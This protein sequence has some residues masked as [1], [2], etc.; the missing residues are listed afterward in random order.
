MNNLLIIN[1]SKLAKNPTTAHARNA[2]VLANSLDAELVSTIEDFEHVN[3]DKIDTF[4]ISGTAFY[5]NTAEIERVIRSVDKPKIVWLNNEYQHTPNSEYG[6]LMKDFKHNSHIISN[7]EERFN[8]FKHYSKYHFLNINTLLYNEANEIIEKKYDICYY[9]TYRPNRRLYFQKYF[10]D[11]YIHVSSST[12]N[13]KK[14]NQLAGGHASWCDRF[15]W[16]L[17]T[18]TLN[19][20]KYSLYIEDEYTHEAFNNLANRFYEC[21][22]CNVVQFFDVSCK[23]TIEK[24]GIDFDDYFFVS[25]AKEL[26]RKIAT[27]NF[28]SSLQIQ[29]KWNKEAALQKEEVINRIKYILNDL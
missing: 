5:P 20:F 28:N 15:S 10:T 12:K 19:N 16:G 24:S 27:D 13:L 11:N 26:K 7:F 29:S 18:E 8:K 3:I 6:R 23:K 25:S 17:G 21:L 22:N 1:T 9:G 2:I 4:L 14:F